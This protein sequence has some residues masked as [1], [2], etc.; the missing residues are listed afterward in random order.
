MG[1]C[2]HSVTGVEGTVGDDAGWESSDGSARADSDA[3]GNLAGAGIGH[4]GSTQD[5]EIPG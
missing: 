4:G 1:L 2:R 5:G 3:A